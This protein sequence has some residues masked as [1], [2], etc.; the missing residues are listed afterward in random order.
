VNP[1]GDS[2]AGCGEQEDSTPRGDKRVLTKY[3]FPHARP[4]VSLAPTW[5]GT[6]GKKPTGV[7]TQPARANMNP[8]GS[9]VSRSGEEGPGRRGLA[10]PVGAMAGQEQALP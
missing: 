2:G 6:S 10:A 3:L 5:Q 1:G 9:H 7:E 4:N 8:S